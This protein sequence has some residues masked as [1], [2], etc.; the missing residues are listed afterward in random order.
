MLFAPSW[1]YEA[2]DSQGYS[3]KWRTRTAALFSGARFKHPSILKSE[4]PGS[5]RL[6]SSSAVR[7]L[8]S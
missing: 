3:L 5:L 7:T 4:Y 2:A 8:E 6:L 1:I